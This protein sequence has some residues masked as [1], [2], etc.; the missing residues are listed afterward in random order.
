MRL[1]RIDAVERLV[2]FNLPM[3]SLVKD[4]RSPF[5]WARF[6]DSIGHEFTRSTRERGKDKAFE[7]AQA[8]ES[9][10]RTGIAPEQ[11]PEP[12]PPTLR[13]VQVENPSSEPQSI[14]MELENFV[15]SS[16]ALPETSLENK[17]LISTCFQNF[18][19]PE[20]SALPLRAL[21]RSLLNGYRDF[22]FNARV[23]K[24]TLNCELIFLRYL[25]QSAMD[26]GR[27][28]T[29]VAAEIPLESVTEISSKPFSLD[30][31]LALL[32]ACI[33]YKH[34]DDWRGIL[35]ICVATG[36]PLSE[37]ANL[38][39][40]DFLA[41]E[42][43]PVLQF[44]ETD[45]TK[46]G[47]A[48]YPLHSLLV[49]YLFLRNLSSDSASFLFPSLADK[50]PDGPNAAVLAFQEFMVVAGITCPPQEASE[51]EGSPVYEYSSLSLKTSL[52]TEEIDAVMNLAF[53]S[54]LRRPYRR[55]RKQQLSAG[56]VPSDGLGMTRTI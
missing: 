50:L 6:R 8:M 32:R 47:V 31:I 19:G 3:A 13:L 56:G 39:S 14:T 29:N 46:Q 45:Q 4:S 52:T 25:C 49:E 16:T 26:A 1:Q 33:H 54:S 35:A 5:Y 12:E 2:S 9:M 23:T 53:Q 15:A 7:V 44:P 43:L 24:K 11:M 37:V 48:S 21:S 55:E 18:L 27:I 36:R 17:T 51:Q 42:V 40:R 28:L 10:A 22:R 41:H 30:Q 34:G 38:R 20:V